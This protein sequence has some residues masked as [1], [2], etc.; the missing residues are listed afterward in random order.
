MKVMKGELDPSCL[1]VVMLPDDTF[2]GHNAAERQALSHL[3]ARLDRR[4]QPRL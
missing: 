3:A 2:P 4:K 1:L